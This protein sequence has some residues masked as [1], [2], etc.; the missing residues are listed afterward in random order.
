MQFSVF[1]ALTNLFEFIVMYFVTR[2]WVSYKNPSS[3]NLQR[4]VFLFVIMYIIISIFAFWAADTYYYW[5][6]FIKSKSYIIFD[7][8]AYEQIYNWL[9]SKVD[10]NYFLWRFF[11]FLPACLLF[12]YT[13]KRLNIINNNFL[14]SVL[15]FSS[16]L[17]FTRGM[18]GHVLL[19]FSLVLL[20]DRENTFKIRFLGLLLFF[21]SYFFHK[22]MFINMIFAILAVLPLKKHTTI[23]L[24]I[25]FPLLIPVASFLINAITSGALSL[26]LGDGVGGAGDRTEL[27]ASQDRSVSNTFGMISNTITYTPIYLTIFYLI[28]KVVFQNCFYGIEKGKVYKYLYNLTFVSLYIGTLFMFVETSTYISTRFLYMGYF[29]LPFVLG[30][31]L[32]MEYK[33][34]AWVRWIII[35]QTFSLFVYW[36]LLIYRN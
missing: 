2:P 18:L 6:E 29:P 25:A 14:L 11:I 17:A 19:L 21:L 22:S 34:N 33:G 4:G 9:A 16:F 28:K 13:A 20:I 35:L 27:Y 31:V 36:F 26:E 15:F 3:N 23:L 12:F 32:S 1:L 8:T 5:D 10:Y 30:K 7:M 24:I